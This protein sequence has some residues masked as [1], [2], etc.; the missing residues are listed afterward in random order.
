MGHDPETFMKTAQ[1]GDFKLF[2]LWVMNNYN[3][4]RAGKSH[5]KYTQLL[6]MYILD[7]HGRS[8]NKVEDRDVTN[9]SAISWLQQQQ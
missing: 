8:L 6:R 4:I 2:W 5:K 9:V 7:A 3:R 1:A